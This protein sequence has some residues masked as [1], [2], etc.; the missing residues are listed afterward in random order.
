MLMS[1]RFSYLDIVHYLQDM[2]VEISIG[3][4]HRYAKRMKG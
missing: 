4:V 1:N 3:S 2:G